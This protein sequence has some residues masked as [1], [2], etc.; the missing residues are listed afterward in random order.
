MAY[1]NPTAAPPIAID[2]SAKP[3]SE[4]PTPSAAPPIASNNPMD[5]PPTVHSPH[6]TPPIATIPTAIWPM[7]TMPL[8]IFGRIVTGS[9][10]EHTCTRG[11]S[12]IVVDDLYSYPYGHP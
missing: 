2:P 1:T 3:P 11:H 5:A 7:S 10:P 6:A 12:P 8:A 9:I 4:T